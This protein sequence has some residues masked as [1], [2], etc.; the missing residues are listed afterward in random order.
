MYDKVSDFLFGVCKLTIYLERYVHNHSGSF[1]GSVW[2][3]HIKTMW[4]ND[5]ILSKTFTQYLKSIK[6]IHE[7]FIYLKCDVK[8]RKISTSGFTIWR[9]FFGFRLGFIQVSLIRRHFYFLCL[10]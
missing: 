7:C 1:C 2:K 6:N 3:S 4:D 10:I 8:Q 5:S 9:V